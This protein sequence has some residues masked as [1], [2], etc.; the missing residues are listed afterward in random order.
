MAFEMQCADYV[1]ATWS[2]YTE[3]QKFT[4]DIHGNASSH[5]NKSLYFILFSSIINWGM[6][7]WYV[8]CICVCVCVLVRVLVCVRS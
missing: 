2:L 6:I 7:S 8:L 1:S 5:A 4:T 3:W